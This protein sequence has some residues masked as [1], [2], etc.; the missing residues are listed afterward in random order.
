MLLSLTNTHLTNKGDEFTTA[1][2]I[3]INASACVQSLHFY[4]SCMHSAR[5]LRSTGKYN[6]DCPILSWNLSIYLRS[7]AWEPELD[8]VSTEH[9]GSR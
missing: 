8:L 6:T 4:F 7:H 2:D 3:E 9:R 1:S 5:M